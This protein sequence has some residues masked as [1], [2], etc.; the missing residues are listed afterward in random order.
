MK[1]HYLSFLKKVLM[2]L[3]RTCKD[4]S[5]KKSVIGGGGRGCRGT[6]GSR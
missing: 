5:F 2:K 3:Q 6:A 1:G 4:M